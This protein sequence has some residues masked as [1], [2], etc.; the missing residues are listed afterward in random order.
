MR[1]VQLTVSVPPP[2]VEAVCGRFWELGARGV[3][4]TE[5]EEATGEA[6]ASGYF[7]LPQASGDPERLPAVA[8][9]REFV[10]LLPSWGL[11]AGTLQV[12]VVDDQDW[13]EAWKAHFHPLRIGRRLVVKP[14][15]EGFEAAA[16]DIVLEIDPG[17]AFGTGTHP[18]TAMCLAIMEDYLRP[19]MV[20][21][22]AGCGS[23]ILSVAAARLG[24]GLVEAWDLEEEACQATAENAAHNG[25]Q[26]KIRV[27]CR[28]AAEGLFALPGRFDLVAANILAEFVLAN[29]AALAY[30]VAPGGFVLAGGIAA[31]R[32]EECRQAFE[33]NGL[34]VEDT[35]RME[36]WVTLVARK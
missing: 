16:G 21:C 15:W 6:K 18:T 19:G 30:A 8:A 3:A 12:Q 33:A 4:V 36:G 28:D 25:V 32:E 14:S 2:S 1:W 10:A 31:A 22:D 13:A 23:G 35:R 24:A 29:A 27:S 34:I 5:P 26:D 20:V 17:M 7:V 11:P 9:V